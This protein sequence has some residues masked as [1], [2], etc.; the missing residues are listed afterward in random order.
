MAER[1]SR[2]EMRQGF[3]DRMRQNQNKNE[4]YWA[5][6]FRKDIKIPFM[7]I[8][9]GFHTVDVLDYI[10]GE[11][12]PEPGKPNYVFE[13]Y[14]YNNIGAGQGPIIA[15]GKT[16]GLPD[17][18][19]EIKAK[20]QRDGASKDVIKSLSPARNPRCLHNVICLDTPEQEQKGVQVHHTS[21]YLFEEY[22]REMA[23]GG[24]TSR[25]GVKQVETIIDF[26]DPVKG[27]SIKY[28]REGTGD[29]T[30]FILHTWADRPEG[31][32]IPDDILDQVFV[33][34]ELIY[35]PSYEEVQI[36]YYGKGE[37]IHTG[38]RSGQEEKKTEEAPSQGRRSRY[39]QES[40][41]EEPARSRTQEPPP[42]E[43]KKETN[44]CPFGHAY[45]V[46]IDKFPKDC[47]NCSEWKPCSR[48]NR[49]GSADTAEKKAEP[50]PAEEKKAEPAAEEKKAE[51]APAGGGERRRR[52][53]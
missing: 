49:E 12:D 48:K 22:L 28:K 13:F 29:K 47:D 19:A 3:R 35:K 24:G 39:D 43:E 17:P 14:Y 32:V 21:S 15:L 18:I 26:T 40:R 10:A 53:A 6:L 1:R 52:R 33:L 30:R 44:P 51:A 31:F 41:A 36:Y 27:R 38:Y 37:G 9:E 7:Q 8:S 4:S 20:A 34:D 45:G 11:N 16:F 2:E 46:D 25:A 5:P 42:A 50:A 23:K